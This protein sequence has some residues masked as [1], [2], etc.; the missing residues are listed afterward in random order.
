MEAPQPLCQNP[1]MAAVHTTLGATLGLVCALALGLGGEPHPGHATLSEADLRAHLEILAAPDVEGRDSPSRGLESAAAYVARRFAE[2]GLGCAPDS[3]A[4]WRLIA[5][6]APLGSGALGAPSALP[7]EEEEGGEDEQGGSRELAGTYLRPFVRPG[8]APL[9]EE[10]RLELV[11]DPDAPS[12]GRRA[13]EYGKDFVPVA[14]FD[15]AVSGELVFAGFAIDSSG[16]KYNDF[17]GL[18]VRGRIALVL[19]GEPDHA[20]RFDGHE[21]SPEG[22]LW[23]KIDHLE[24]AGAEG[25]LVVR[26]PRDEPGE[27]S[28]TGGDEDDSEPWLAYRYTWARFNGGMHR[29]EP[30]KRL[31]LLELSPACATA[32]LGRDVGEL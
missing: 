7:M 29:P 26:R 32:L 21:L 22:S 19:Q 1:L 31:P 11:G 17:A 20:R 2:A 23:S 6:D 27:P 18:A 24:D 14:G 5:G 3:V 25:V 10:C 9:P 16:E 4:A 15:G 12:G 8:R 28:T 30:R 13:F